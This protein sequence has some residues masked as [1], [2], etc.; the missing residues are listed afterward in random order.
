MCEAT[1]LASRIGALIL[2]EYS[3]LRA[4]TVR[5]LVIHSA[6]WTEQMLREFP[7][8]N[9]Q[10]KRNLLRCYGYGVPK[11]ETALY[12]A[13]NSVTLIAEDKLQP[14]IKESGKDAKVNE[15]GLHELPWAKDVLLGLGE[16]EVEMRVTLSYFIEPNPNGKGYKKM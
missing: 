6:S 5:A 2:A 4:E 11:L 1:A 7:N 10:D 12:S 15:M 3:N 14:F 16:L 8:N 9:Q 13:N